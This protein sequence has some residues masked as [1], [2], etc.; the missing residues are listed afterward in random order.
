VRPFPEKEE[1]GL[2]GEGERILVGGICD[3]SISSS[4]DTVRSMT[5]FLF[6]PKPS[7]SLRTVTSL[8][9][10][11]LPSMVIFCE[12]F[13]LSSSALEPFSAEIGMKSV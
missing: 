7:K 1:V 4:T 10:E 9:S 5:V 3:P 13:Y 6:E 2:T 11:S 12:R 8:E